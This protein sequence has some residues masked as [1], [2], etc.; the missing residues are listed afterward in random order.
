MASFRARHLAAQCWSVS[1]LVWGTGAAEALEQFGKRLQAALFF[2]GGPSEVLKGIKTPLVPGFGMDRLKV[3]VW[4][5]RASEGW[6]DAG[7]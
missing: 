1:R 2:R 7:I 5:A 4:S 6:E 3:W